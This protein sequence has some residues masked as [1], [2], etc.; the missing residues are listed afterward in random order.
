MDVSANKA[1]EQEQRVGL[2]VISNSCSP[3][4][5]PGS[6]TLKGAEAAESA[7]KQ[8]HGPSIL[9]TAT[10]GFFARP[11]TPN[12]E[13]KQ[14]NGVEAFKPCIQLLPLEFSLT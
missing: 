1:G 14:V 9:H 10:H 7:L 12:L 3:T 4:C 5:S 8:I 11:G 13:A 6:R 2:L